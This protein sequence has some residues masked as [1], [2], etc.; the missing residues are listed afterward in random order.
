MRAVDIIGKKRDGHALSDDEIRA[1]VRGATSGDWPDYQVAALLMAIVLRGMDR[2]ETVTLTTAMVESGVKLD[3]S[4][5]PGFKVDKH[6]T[7][8]VGDK[9]SPV[10]APLAAACGCIVPKMSGRGLGHSGGTLDKLESI[11]GYRVGLSIA[12]F[13][14]VVAKAGFALVG[15]T[16]EIAPA[17]K[18]LYALRDVTGTVESVPLITASIMSKKIAEGIEGLVLDVKCGRGAFMKTDAHARE[19][20]ESLV[21]TGQAN[22]VRTVAHI[23]AMEA[24]LGRAV[25]NSLEVIESLETLKGRGPGDLEQVA[26]VVAAEMLQMARPALFRD[27][28]DREI[29]AALT[30]GRGLEKMAQVIAEQGGDPRIIDDYRLLPTAPKQA[31]L[32]AEKTGYLATIHA[33]DVGRAAMLLG[34]GRERKE[35]PIDHTAGIVLHVAVGNLVRPGEPLAELHYRDE[36]RLGAALKMLNGAFPVQDAPPE[37]Q[38][39][40]LATVRGD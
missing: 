15:Q 26:V 33:D 12:E 27:A 1:F 7:G 11:P 13:R 35:D 21:A 39:K 25:G 8:G 17:D 20:A 6:S 22:G 10:L 28:A 2:R 38:D 29:R 9:T 36:Q 4:D 23:T 34:A 37:K 14:R 30:S 19:L 32:R 24:P 31:L 3:L 16:D 5:I 40:I 18:V